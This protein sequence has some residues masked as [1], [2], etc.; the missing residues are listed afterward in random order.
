MRRTP[1]LLLLALSCG[2]NQS[3]EH[4]L[5]P[6][7]LARAPIVPGG[8]PI[9]GLL[10]QVTT[11]SGTQPLLIDSAYPTDSLAR[12][13]CAGGG[14]PGWT[15]TGDMELRDG[16]N[17]PFPVR[18]SFRN[19]GLFDLCPGTTGDAT[20]QA[21]GVMGGPLLANF[22]VGLVL[23]RVASESATMTLWPVF[24]GADDQLAQD[25][26]T[27][28]HFT[29]RGGGSLAQGNG[30]STV[31][32]P[33]SRIVL[34]A[35]AAPR[36]FSTTEAVET[37]AQGESAVKTSGQSLFLAVGTG[38]G[39]LIL[40]QPA[41]DRIAAE[42]G[43]TSDAGT[44]GDLYTPFSN[45][46]IPA[47]FLTLPRLALFQGTT[48]STWIGACAELARARR[49][50][51][52]LANQ[53]SGACF[54]PCDADGG[55]A[56]TTHAYLELGGSLDLAVISETSDLMRSLNV[57]LGSNPHIDGIVGAGTLAGTRLRLDYPSSSQGR[58]IATCEEG[59]TRESCW[60]AP[61]CP[62]WSANSDKHVCFGQ[63]AHVWAPV[64][65]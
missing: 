49:I 62:G 36:S 27:S 59:S 30:G 3:L 42:A 23:P 7:P 39:P 8:S 16:V 40:S 64:C 29:L 38:E 17:L 55:Q 20:T 4:D 37:C 44:A 9:G 11:A 24:P 33:D 61:S 22:S 63:E 25:G 57:D 51:W 34:A 21:A 43:M 41:W 58:V 6:I 18:A 60:P 32:L 10:A 2:S 12:S 56:I 26:W 65:P 45:T 35:C 28:L 46:P 31:T 19:V 54:Q 53:A 1:F 14:T 48:D 50:E 13:A 47:H 15:Y 5:D 52:A